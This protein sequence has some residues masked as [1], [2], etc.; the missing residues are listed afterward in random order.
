MKERQPDCKPDCKP[1]YKIDGPMRL[2][3]AAPALMIWCGIWLTGF[4]EAH[5]IF[6]LPAISFSLA[7]IIGICPGMMIAK[8]LM[9]KKKSA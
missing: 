8:R 4:A 5:W 6:Y 2:F 7:A 9:G 1:D 3:L